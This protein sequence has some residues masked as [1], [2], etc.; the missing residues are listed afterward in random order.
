MHATIRTTVAPGT[1]AISAPLRAWLA[2]ER[3]AQDLLA[4]GLLEAARLEIAAYWRAC[5]DEEMA[6]AVRRAPRDSLEACARMVRAG[7][8]IGQPPARSVLANAHRMHAADLAACAWPRRVE[9]PPAAQREPGEWRRNATRDALVLRADGRQVACLPLHRLPDDHPA[10]R[11]VDPSEYLRRERYY[12]A[13]GG[14]PA[15][16]T[17]LAELRA[18]EGLA[19]VAA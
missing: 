2:A 15:P 8:A 13:L 18:R 6:G 17:S 4:D 10:W 19:P 14:D 7:R 3:R 1:A 9:Q 16:V 12:R 5:G 11:G